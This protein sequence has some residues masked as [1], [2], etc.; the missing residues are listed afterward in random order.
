MTRIMKKD[1]R[2]LSWGRKKLL[3]FLYL[4]SRLPFL[5]AG[6]CV[7]P[8]AVQLADIFLGIGNRVSIKVRRRKFN[9]TKNIP[10][11]C[12][13]SAFFDDVACEGM[14]GEMKLTRCRESR[15]HDAF[16]K[17]SANPLVPDRL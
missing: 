5:F 16:T 2:W 4:S 17:A 11:H 1:Y 15:L 14:P 6:V 13:G 7:F 9:V 3:Y 8:D 10:D 12:K